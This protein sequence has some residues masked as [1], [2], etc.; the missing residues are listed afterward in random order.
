MSKSYKINVRSTRVVLALD[1]LLDLARSNGDP[2]V[3]FAAFGDAWYS[4]G[5]KRTEQGTRRAIF[6]LARSF[7]LERVVLGIRGQR[8]DAVRLGVPEVEA[9]VKPLVLAA[10]RASQSEDFEPLDE[11]AYCD[12]SRLRGLYV[13][14]PDSRNVFR[15]FIGLASLG[16]LA[17][18]RTERVRDVLIGER[19]RLRGEGR[20]ST[21]SRLTSEGRAQAVRVYE[22]NVGIEVRRDGQ[23]VVI[24]GVEAV[25]AFLG[26]HHDAA[27]TVL[28]SCGAQI[29][30]PGRPPMSEHPALDP[31]PLDLV[32]VV[33]ET[34]HLGM[35]ATGWRI[36]G[37]TAYCDKPQ[38]EAKGVAAH[39]RAVREDGHP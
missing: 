9:V 35:V 8:P 11:V 2:W 23:A 4:R 28:A 25:A 21:L 19:V 12:P 5:G 18:L 29:R 22:D 1:E 36:V 16:R 17:G 13:G 3:S 27:R 15:T 34:T 26:V 24:H 39:R 30:P 37:T 14:A 38:C 6:R 32:C 7:R 10:M 31:S 20:P 33:C